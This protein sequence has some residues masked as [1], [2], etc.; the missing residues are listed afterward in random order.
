MFILL[1]ARIL[2]PLTTT[3]VLSVTEKPR[4]LYRA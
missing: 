2:G 1:R 4:I 3:A